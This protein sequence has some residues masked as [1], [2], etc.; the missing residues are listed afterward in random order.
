MICDAEDEEKF[1]KLLGPMYRGERTPLRAWWVIAHAQT[2]PGSV[3]R[4]LLTRV[5]FS[6]VGST[7]IMVF[8]RLSEAAPKAYVTEVPAV[9]ASELGVGHARLVGEGWLSDPRGLA[10][11]GNGRLAVADVGLDRIVFFDDEGRYL[12]ESPA[13]PMDRPESVAWAPA[14][15]MV[16]ADTWNHRLLLFRPGDE[17]VSVMP[18]PEGGWFGPRGVAVA[19]DGAIAVTDTGNKRVVL[20]EPGRA[21]DFSLRL[22]GGGGDEPGRFSEP[23]GL[24]WLDA[25]RLVVCDTGNHRLQILD[26]SGAVLDLIE[27]DDAWQDF[28]SRPQIAVLNDGRILVSDTPS[29]S[30]WLIQ[31]DD[32]KR[33]ELGADGIIPTGLATANGALYIGDSNGRV[34]LGPVTVS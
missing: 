14:D 32:L 31:G 20:Y 13:E 6:E 2:T 17:G 26:R 1:K 11:D 8:R 15:V 29:A 9:L 12:E 23:V 30:L 19:S 16:V 10:V 28:Y 24:A 7:D 3:L 34:L 5:P 25:D 4:W 18:E 21:T 33:L 22:L 27:L